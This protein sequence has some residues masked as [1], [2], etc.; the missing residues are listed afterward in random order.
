MT[1]LLRRVLVG[2][3]NYGHMTRLRRFISKFVV[4]ARC[5][6]AWYFEFSP[7]FCVG[8]STA[9]WR[10]YP[11]TCHVRKVWPYYMRPVTGRRGFALTLTRAPW[12]A[13][14]L[15][16]KSPKAR[17]TRLAVSYGTGADVWKFDIEWTRIHWNTRV[18]TD[19]WTRV[20]NRDSPSWVFYMNIV[21]KWTRPW[22]SWANINYD[23][24][25]V[26]ISRPSRT[27]AKLLEITLGFNP[28]CGE[29]V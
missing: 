23:R 26:G 15:L 21:G 19:K 16:A 24:W 28:L 9:Y 6:G 11:P 8:A 3:Q 5:F 17:Y 20:M 13:T 29:F 12:M 10:V 27:E 2:L 4:L 14:A 25:P 22:L 18:H 1:L 7:T